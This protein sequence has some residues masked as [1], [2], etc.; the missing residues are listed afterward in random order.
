[1]ADWADIKHDVAEFYALEGAVVYVMSK[2]TGQ[3]LGLKCL[4]NC[5]TGGWDGIHRGVCNYDMNGTTPSTVADSFVLRNSGAGFYLESIN[6]IHKNRLFKADVQGWRRVVDDRSDINRWL[7][8]D[9]LCFLAKP[10][11]VESGR[12]NAISA[13]GNFSVETRLVGVT[14][15]D[16]PKRIHE[17]PPRGWEAVCVDMPIRGEVVAGEIIMNDY[18]PFSDFKKDNAVAQQLFYITTKSPPDASAWLANPTNKLNC[19][20][21]LKGARY[22][23]S[24]PEPE[25]GINWS[26]A[27]VN[28]DQFVTELW[29]NKRYLY[30]EDPR[31]VCFRAQD[32]IASDPDLRKIGFSVGCLITCS[33]EPIAY[34]TRSMLDTS[35]QCGPQCVQMN[36][37][38]A[39]GNVQAKNVSQICTVQTGSSSSTTSTTDS[40]SSTPSVIIPANDKSKGPTNVSTYIAI[41]LGGGVAVGLLLALGAASRRAN[42]ERELRRRRR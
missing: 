22:K 34:K 18:A 33:E 25:T 37:I 12:A 4:F 14:Q 11:W 7:A 32:D 38:A 9:S 39:Q 16:K 13:D 41:G 26:D 15:W 35:K 24:C 31:F 19:C 40:S 29:R 10:E 27:Q 28:C 17:L 3:Y 21:G 30:L 20:L 2:V 42:R 23:S 1:M 36:N 5:Q 6:S 8:A